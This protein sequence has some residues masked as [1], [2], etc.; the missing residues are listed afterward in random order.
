MS[1]SPPAKTVSF[2][3]YSFNMHYIFFFIFIFETRVCRTEEIMS[4]HIM[5]ILYIHD[6]VYGIIF[7]SIGYLFERWGLHGDQKEK[8]GW[9]LE[10]KIK[11]HPKF[12]LIVE[13]IQIGIIETPSDFQ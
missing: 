13:F 8:L 1:S 2:N 12:I 7:D 9:Y 4:D 6:F 11:P 5:M 10:G 3:M